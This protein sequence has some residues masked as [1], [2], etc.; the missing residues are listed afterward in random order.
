M[1]TLLL[2]RPDHST[3][4]YEGLRKNS[5]I[6]IKY[7][8]FSAFKKGSLL[9]QW[10]PSVKS[11]DS[12]VEICYG[13]TFFHR[14]LD[15]LN[16]QIP[17]DYYERENQISEYFFNQIL[18]KY[19]NEVNIIHYWP[20]YCH[21]SVKEFQWENPKTKLLADVYA[22]HPDYVREILE[23]EFDKFGLSMETSH[24]IKSRERDISS[25]EGVENMLVPSE[26]MA[27]IYQRYYPNTKIFTASYG[28][29]N[30]N[31]IPINSF[32]RA[33]KT[34]VKLI[35][36]GKVSIEKGCTYLLEA[37]KL[38]PKTEFQLDLIGDIPP[39]QISI[40]KPYFGISNI[41]FMGKLPNLKILEVLPDYHIFVLPSLTDAYSLAVSEALSYKLP[42]IITENVGHKEDVRKFEVGEVCEVKSVDAL[43]QAILTLQN[44]EYRQYLRTNIDKFIENSQQNSYSLKVLKIYNQLLSN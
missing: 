12:E 26:Y 11:V 15:F 2:A 30:L 40:F 36:V 42:V 31:K 24:F 41:N 44:E 5:E 13:F 21:K 7:H 1:K 27:E 9:N 43:L 17:F 37:M 19:S 10:K 38:L 22:A 16:K 28:L 14:L 4:L 35:F 39:N 18:Q 25:L 20:I 8:T 34:P 33:F 29:L 32:K 3:F 23:P 6:D